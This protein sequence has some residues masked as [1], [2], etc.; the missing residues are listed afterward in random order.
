MDSHIHTPD[1]SRGRR[2]VYVDG[3]LIEAVFYADTKRGIVRAY[4]QPL[5]LDKHRKRLLSYVLRGIV[6]VEVS[7]G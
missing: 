4:R 2:R 1:D 6:T 5:R 3:V 7:N